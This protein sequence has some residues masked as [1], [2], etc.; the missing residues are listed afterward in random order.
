M[1]RTADLSDRAIRRLVPIGFWWSEHAPD[2]PHPRSFI[3]LEWDSTE[4][5]AVLYYLESA[6]RTPYICCGWSQCRF[7][8]KPNGTRD[9]TDGTFIF[10]EGLVHYIRKHSVRP[11][12][13]FLEYMRS[14][15]FRMADLPELQPMT[16]Q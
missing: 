5:R 9:H 3:D 7:C 15:N 6:Y 4:R 16:R 11:E 1:R 13:R 14:L 10:P 2:L 12:E 8:Q